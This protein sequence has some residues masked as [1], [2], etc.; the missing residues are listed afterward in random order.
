MPSIKIVV[1]HAHG[2]QQASDR[3]L[4]FM[5]QMKQQYKDQVSDLQE[6]WQENRL[7]YSFRTFGLKV[8]GAVEVQ[9]QQVSLHADLPLAAIMFK[10]KIEQEIRSTLE[11][12]LG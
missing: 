11:R 2:Q 3:L 5:T 9:E 10:G 6:T 1:P 4:G 7:D 8:R 12:V